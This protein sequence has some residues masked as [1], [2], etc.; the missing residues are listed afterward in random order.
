M[1]ANSGAPAQPSAAAA[2][3]GAAEVRSPAL[4]AVRDVLGDEDAL[5]AALESDEKRAAFEDFANRLSD[6]TDEYT[7]EFCTTRTLLRYLRA[8]NFKVKDSEKMIRST[9]A[10]RA[11]KQPQTVTCR[12]CVDTPSCHSMRHIGFDALDRPVIYSVFSQSTN[13]TASEAADH[14][15]QVLEACVRRM[16]DGVETFVWIMDFHGFG[17][18]DANPQNAIVFN[19]IFSY[20]YPERLGAAILVDTPFIFRPVFA[21]I[22][23]VFA[24]E[25]VKKVEM[26]KHSQM[27]ERCG[28]WM[29]DLM[30]WLETEMVQNRDKEL[31]KTKRYWMPPPEGESHDPRAH[32]EIARRFPDD[33]FNGMLVPMEEPETWSCN[34]RKLDE[35]G[36]ELDAKATKALVAE[37][38]AKRAAETTPAAE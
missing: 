10:W 8:R 17:V 36:N 37:R 19:G 2:S 32:G 24:A 13:R 35:D 33:H 12:F 27:R 30:D 9:F 34:G 11:E 5:L 6:V 18:A 38:A 21:A 7:V 4:K 1:N 16:T 28:E 15:V 14:M 3:H 22:K 25:T 26:M 31:T 23:A 29:G 20:H